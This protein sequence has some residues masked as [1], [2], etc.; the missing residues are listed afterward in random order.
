MHQHLD[1]LK[2]NL[3]TIQGKCPEAYKDLY[4]V[5]NEIYLSLLKSI[6][7]VERMEDVYRLQGQIYL[8]EK[9]LDLFQV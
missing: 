6:S 4:E 3:I 8:V 7:K 9:I 2:S 1:K 5:L